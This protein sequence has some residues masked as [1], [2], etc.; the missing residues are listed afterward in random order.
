MPDIQAKDLMTK[1]FLRIS[2]Q[3]TLR[4]TMGIILHGEQKKYDTGGLVIID[5]E[6]EF[7]GIITPHQIVQGLLNDWQP[8]EGAENQN[9]DFLKSAESNLARTIEDILPEPQASVALDASLT[10]LTHMAGNAEYDCIPVIDQGRVEGLVYV[11]DI[12]KATASI[13]LNPETDGI[14]LE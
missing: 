10:R 12:F 14:V 4:E 7:A 1:R 2:T 3:H 8:T 5:Q 9:E 13:A 6:G 11:T